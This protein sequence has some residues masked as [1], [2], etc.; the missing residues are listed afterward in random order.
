MSIRLINEVMDHAPQDLTFAER[1]AL[2]VFAEDANKD[3]RELVHPLSWPAFANRIGVKTEKQVWNLAAALVRKGV[4]VC[5]Q[6]GQKY[7]PARYQIPMLNTSQLPEIKDLSDVSATRNRGP[8]EDVQVPENRDLKNPQGVDSE[9]LRSSQVPENRDLSEAA[10]YKETLSFKTN[11]KKPPLEREAPG[12]LTLVDVEIEI[13]APKRRGPVGDSEEFARF[14][15]AYPRKIAKPAARKAWT[16]VVAAGVDVELVISAA[17]FY[18]LRRIGENPK[19][20]PYPAK[21]LNDERWEDTP[22]PDYVEPS[23]RAV[24]MQRNLTRVVETAQR[25]GYDPM[26][27]LFPD[28]VPA[29]HPDLVRQREETEAWYRGDPIPARR[30]APNAPQEAR[31]GVSDAS[32]GAGWGQARGRLF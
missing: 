26:A 19:Y 24:A 10:P 16:K 18:S 32:G 28:S 15:H 5:L 12:T 11:P 4:L 21:W 27:L 6:R 3:T 1:L 14:W 9:D 17:E 22:D 13:V 31:S 23:K 20:T 7:R 2:V 25:E 30:V 8:E 29:D